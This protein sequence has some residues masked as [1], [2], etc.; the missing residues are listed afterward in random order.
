MRSSSP[1]ILVVVLVLGGCGGATAPGAS[2]AGPDGRLQLDA[3]APEAAPLDAAPPPD[4]GPPDGTPYVPTPGDIQFAAVSAAPA[5]EQILF[6]DWMPAPNRVLTMQPDGSGA[7]TVFEAYR[8]WSMGAARDGS[9]LAFSCGDPQ[10]ELHYGIPIGDAIQHSWLYDMAT[11]TVQLLAY[12]NINDECH[13]F[14]PGDTAIYVCRRYDFQPDG[15]NRGWRLGRLDLPGGD[16]TFLTP[17][18]DRDWALWP[19]PT[20]DGSALYYGRI[21]IAGSSQTR[22][23]M[24]LPL[25]PGAAELVRAN[26][27]VIT[28]SPDGARLAFQNWADGQRLYVVG[29]DGNGLTKVADRQNATTARWSPDGAR[30]AF[31][32]NDSALN[33]SHIETV[34]ADG[35][36]ATAPQR[37]RDCGQTGEM[38]TEMEW[39][40]R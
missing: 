6:N 15:S 9:R 16:F 27:S 34:A 25:P 5:G 29:L 20:L 35:S 36:E 37:L 30:I 10:Q 24:R 18:V 1:A 40:V 14:A 3:V 26:A 31:L 28:L 4:A 22:S 7:A 39:I 38:I 12:G 33:C 21:Q 32:W 19:Q 23:V 17:D 13:T 2:D 11:Q 8:V